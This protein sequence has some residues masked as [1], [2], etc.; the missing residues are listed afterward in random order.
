MGRI[1]VLNSE[2]DAGAGDW[3]GRVVV[4][5]KK[6]ARAGRRGFIGRVVG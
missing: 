5:R 2:A 6:A 4:R 1:W 3:E